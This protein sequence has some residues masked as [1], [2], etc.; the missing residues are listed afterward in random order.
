MPLETY[1]S[2]QIQALMI[3]YLENYVFNYSNSLFRTYHVSKVY[4][5]SPSA[6]YFPMLPVNGVLVICRTFSAIFRHFLETLGKY[7]NCLP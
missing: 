2:S 3:I 1:Y 5:F 4:S 6:H 7:L